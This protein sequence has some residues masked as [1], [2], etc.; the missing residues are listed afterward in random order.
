MQSNIRRASLQA[1]ELITYCTLNRLIYLL[2]SFLQGRRIQI[3][4]KLS[5]T[6]FPTQY[7]EAGYQYQFQL[8]ASVVLAWAYISSIQQQSCSSSIKLKISSACILKSILE[9]L[10]LIYRLKPLLIKKRDMPINSKI[11]LF[12]INSASRSYSAQLFCI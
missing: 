11:Q 8:A 12:I 1:E 4:L 10:K 6:L 2:S 7:I 9:Q 5:Q 3:F